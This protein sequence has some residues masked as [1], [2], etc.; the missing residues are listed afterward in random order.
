METPHLQ[1]KLKF[2]TDKVFYSNYRNLDEI[3]DFFA[4]FVIVIFYEDERSMRWLY[5]GKTPILQRGNRIIAGITLLSIALNIA[6]TPWIPSNTN[7]YDL[8]VQTAKQQFSACLFAFVLMACVIINVRIL[9]GESATCNLFTD[10]LAHRLLALLAAFLCMFNFSIFKQTI[11]LIV[12]FTWDPILLQ[13]DLALL[14]GQLLP[15]WLNTYLPIES[16]NHY[17]DHCYA[18]WVTISG[19]ILL[20][21]ALSNDNRQRFHFLIAWLLCWIVL[22]SV[23]ALLFSSVGPCFYAHFYDHVPYIISR[24]YPLQPE[25]ALLTD[26][27]KTFLLSGSQQHH[28]AVGLGISAFPSLHVATSVINAHTLAAAHPLLGRLGWLYVGA[29][30]LSAIYLGFHYVIDC[31]IAIIIAQYIWRFTNQ[32]LSDYVHSK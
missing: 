28:Y 31:V 14:G 27:A 16:L 30:S 24:S 21:R 22:G 4:Y 25:G 32:R 10:Y 1:Y 7:V 2:H 8:F 19:A 17:T 15:D 29:V 20:W 3:I 23:I 13:I 11:P 9:R 12:P 5:L 26:T 18:S 6:I